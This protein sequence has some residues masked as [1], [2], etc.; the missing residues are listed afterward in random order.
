MI[1]L[2]VAGSV[3]VTFISDKARLNFLLTVPKVLW[4][5]T[6]KSS[7]RWR[8]A[9]GFQSVLKPVETLCPMA[10]FLPLLAEEY[11]PKFDYLVANKD[12]VKSKQISQTENLFWGWAEPSSHR[13]LS[14]VICVCISFLEISFYLVPQ[15]FGAVSKRNFRVSGAAALRQIA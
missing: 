10:L 1:H 12:Q 8:G 7:Q 5:C 9:S 2:K 11:S 3:R 13:S 15:V 6:G 4:W 14:C